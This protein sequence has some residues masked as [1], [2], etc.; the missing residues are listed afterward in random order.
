MN[1]RSRIAKPRLRIN[2]LSAA[3]NPVLAG[4]WDGEVGCWIGS[5]GGDA[6]Q[7]A[8][9][10]LQRGQ[11]RVVAVTDAVG[12]LLHDLGVALRGEGCRRYRVARDNEKVDGRYVQ[13]GGQVR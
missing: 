1:G 4:L 5:W 7:R 12:E 9:E 11:L 8:G 6:W 10:I 2:P 3:A 13:F